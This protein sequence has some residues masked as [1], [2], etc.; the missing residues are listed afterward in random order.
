[1]DMQKKC[2]SFE[3]MVKGHRPDNPISNAWYDLK[4]Q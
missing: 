1:M 3:E 4:T 2:S